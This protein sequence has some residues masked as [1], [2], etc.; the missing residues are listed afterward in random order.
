MLHYYNSFL[1][2]LKAKGFTKKIK[3]FLKIFWISTLFI[4]PFQW[5]N[6]L[7][8]RVNSGKNKLFNQVF[9]V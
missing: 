8:E 1:A 9:I 5:D 7:P 2:I 3:L 6:W 4:C